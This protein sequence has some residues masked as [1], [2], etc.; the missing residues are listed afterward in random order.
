M[1]LHG[2]DSPPDLMHELVEK[3]ATKVDQNNEPLYTKKEI[4][5]MH[6]AIDKYAKFT[7]LMEKNSW[8]L[9]K[10]DE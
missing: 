9:Q 5:N 2:V 4:K 10:L 7:Y 1:N 3:L 6:C 8:M